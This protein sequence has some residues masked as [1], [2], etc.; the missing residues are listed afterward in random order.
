MFLVGSVAVANVFLTC[1]GAALTFCRPQCPESSAHRLCNKT[2]A[3]GQLTLATL[4]LHPC[5][6]RQPLLLAPMCLLFLY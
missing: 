3:L 1:K 5:S 4:T 2:E 6:H